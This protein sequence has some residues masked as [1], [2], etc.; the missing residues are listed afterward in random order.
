MAHLQHYLDQIPDNF[1][2]LEGAIARVFETGQQGEL[3]EA[4]VQKWID[5]ANDPDGAR[6]EGEISGI[7]TRYDLIRDLTGAAG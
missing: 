1:K 4:R 2:T 5:E 3:S 6:D 7:L